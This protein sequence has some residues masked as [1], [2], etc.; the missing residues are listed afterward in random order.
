MERFEEVHFKQNEE[1]IRLETMNK[2][3]QIEIGEC[4]ERESVMF[5]MVKEASIIK[6]KDRETKAKLLLT[7][8][9]PSALAAE[10]TPRTMKESTIGEINILS[11][12]S[13]TTRIE[14]DELDEETPVEQ[15]E[16]LRSDTLKGSKN[17][18]YFENLVFKNI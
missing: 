18:I 14:E 5:S 8:H 11:K 7:H 13:R 9:S 3:L 10:F 2:I 4:K 17:R 15:R 16:G 12:K 6:E 1:I